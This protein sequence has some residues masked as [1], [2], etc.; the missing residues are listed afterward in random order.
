MGSSNN[1]YLLEPGQC[2]SQDG[3]SS[4]IFLGYEICEVPE[5]NFAK[6]GSCVVIELSQ[7]SHEYALR[8]C[9]FVFL[10]GSLRLW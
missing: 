6:F 9:V 7:S 1:L 5:H 8:H 2:S 10:I 3:A 4:E